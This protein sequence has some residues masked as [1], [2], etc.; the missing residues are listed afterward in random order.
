MAASA[1]ADAG[2]DDAADVSVSVNSAVVVS[3]P[4]Q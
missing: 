2:F 3:L 1:D 4:Q